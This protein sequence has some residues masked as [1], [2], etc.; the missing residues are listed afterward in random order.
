MPLIEA[1]G[2]CCLV[3]TKGLVG[4]P[5]RGG[6]ELGHGVALAVGHTGVDIQGDE[7]KL[8]GHRGLV[9]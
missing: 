8:R 9:P 5:A 7:A 1:L 2:G 3:G 4:M 6:H